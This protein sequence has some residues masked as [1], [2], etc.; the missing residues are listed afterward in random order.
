MIHPSLF[1]SEVEVT[2]CIP[3]PPLITCCDKSTQTISPYLHIERLDLG[4]RLMERKQQQVN[5]RLCPAI[6]QEPL[7]NPVPNNIVLLIPN[8]HPMKNLCTEAHNYEF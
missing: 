2:P 5:K 1:V 8:N 6:K 7:E 4:K 3:T